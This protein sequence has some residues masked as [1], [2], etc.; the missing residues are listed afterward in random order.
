MYNAL[1]FPL[2]GFNL[3]MLLISGLAN[4]QRVAWFGEATFSARIN[5]LALFFGWLV[6]A[7]V[8]VR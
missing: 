7:L 1:V 2:V 8:V 4:N 5:N 6:S 3:L